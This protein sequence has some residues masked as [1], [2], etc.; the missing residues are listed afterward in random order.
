LNS[1]TEL[2]RN[3]HHHL[4]LHLLWQILGSTKDGGDIAPIKAEESLSL[5]NLVDKLMMVMG[6]GTNDDE[7]NFEKM[8]VVVND[9]TTDYLST[10]NKGLLDYGKEGSKRLAQKQKKNIIMYV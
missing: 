7:K 8:S 9:P 3:P 5:S 1:S 10:F 6:V 4:L 2:T